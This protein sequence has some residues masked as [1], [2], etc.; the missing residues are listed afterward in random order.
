MRPLTV[1]LI[2]GCVIAWFRPRRLR[3]NR[4]AQTVARIPFAYT[5]ASMASRG[6]GR[7]WICEQTSEAIELL[8]G[9]LA[10]FRGQCRLTVL[11]GARNI[12]RI[13]TRCPGDLSRT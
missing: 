12:I 1:R 7:D 10:F 8:F 13:R 6:Y 9:S 2:V 4:S 5:R 3:C 11:G